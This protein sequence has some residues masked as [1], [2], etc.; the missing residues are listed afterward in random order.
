M[1]TATK[2]LQFVDNQ[3]KT[4]SN[5]SGTVNSKLKCKTPNTNH[6]IMMNTKMVDIEDNLPP[7]K[8]LLSNNNSLTESTT[9]KDY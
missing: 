8:K 3:K 7:K 5:V 4:I 2:L 6:N 9:S 1:L